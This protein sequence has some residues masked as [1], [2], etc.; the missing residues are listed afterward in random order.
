M[1]LKGM[2]F[3]YGLAWTL[4]LLLVVVTLFGSYLMPS[5]IGESDK[6]QLAEQVID[7]KKQL[8]APPFAPSGE[9][10]LG[11]DH[12]GY[13]MLSLLLNGAKYS[14]GFGLLVTAARFLLAVPLGLYSGA[15]GRLR[16]VVRVLQIVTTSVPAVLILF[17]ALY[18]LAGMLYINMGLLP[19]DPRVQFF[20]LAVFIM[21]VGAGVFPLAD[22]FADRAKFF[23]DKEFISASRT[24][25][26]S[27]SR[28][29]WRHLVP[30]LRPELLYGF[31]TELVQVMFLIGQLAVLSV[32]V[33]GSEPFH[34]GEKTH[35]DF[36]LLSTTGEWGALIAYGIKYINSY[37]WLVAAP[38]A[39]LA[40]SVL[41]LSFFAHTLQQRLEHPGFY[42]QQKKVWRN[43]RAVAAAG[44]VVAGC[45]VLVL[46]APNKAPEAAAANGE[47][48]ASAVDQVIT[49]AN[50]QS[51]AS[52]PVKAGEFMKYLEQ[53]R[54]DYAQA[55]FFATP[56]NKP[57]QPFDRWV[58]ALASGKYKFLKAE[59]MFKRANG[60]VGYEVELQVQNPEGQVEIWVLEML[61]SERIQSGKGGPGESVPIVLR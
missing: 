3:Q 46:L 60:Q 33:G 37:Q 56:S 20:E 23:S 30:H 45:L 31:V 41:I 57:P 59:R 36:I 51:L 53:N 22:Q 43:K 13:D 15:T 7:G 21:L 11:T 48:G 47:F 25:G 42:R 58:E 54:W 2:R 9:H 17:T 61:G 40:V 34:L 38:C 19:N 16:G 10:W 32:F 39:F 29:V 24:L 8:V 6:I 5:A 44:V 1:T 55:A 18:Q 50:K 52:T 26:A 12:R 27:T 14:I 28:I 49:G 4:L 35:I